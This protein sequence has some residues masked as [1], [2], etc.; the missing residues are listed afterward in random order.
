MG[1]WVWPGP[2]GAGRMYERRGWSARSRC[3]KSG[4]RALSFIDV[5]PAFARRAQRC[6]LGDTA[7]HMLLA[8]LARGRTALGVHARIA[9]GEPAPGRVELD[10]PTRDEL[11]P[12]AIPL[13]GLAAVPVDGADIRHH[14]RHARDS[15]ETRLACLHLRERDRHDVLARAQCIHRQLR[16]LPAA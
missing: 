13:R 2:G 15:P 5:D 1:S 9:R 12:V 8:V 6:L 11:A 4:A 16:L 7:E 3:S 10:A 14:V